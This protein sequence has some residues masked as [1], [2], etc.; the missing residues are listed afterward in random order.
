M[1]E[2]Q[3]AEQ[4]QE[5]E[6]EGQLPS[7]H[8]LALELGLAL[9]LRGGAEGAVDRFTASL[10]RAS[11]LGTPTRRAAAFP[12]LPLLCW[13]LSVGNLRL[14]ATLQKSSHWGPFRFFFIPDFI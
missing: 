13:P 7:H 6:L 11:G 14:Y 10:Q 8:A 4:E 3:E 9:A 2:Q 12:C 5:E 1:E